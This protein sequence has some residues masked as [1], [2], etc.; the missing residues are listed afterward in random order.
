MSSGV[1]SAVGQYAFPDGTIA[2]FQ[3]NEGLLYRE[4]ER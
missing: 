1:V 2:S 3:E 4:F